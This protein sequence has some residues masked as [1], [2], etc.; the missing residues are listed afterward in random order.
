M[1]LYFLFTTLHVNIVICAFIIYRVANGVFEK[2]FGANWAVSVMA[3]GKEYFK[4]YLYKTPPT[5]TLSWAWIG[6]SGCSLF[7][8]FV[9][10]SFVHGF[11]YVQ[12]YQRRCF[13]LFSFAKQLNYSIF[14]IILPNADRLMFSFVFLV[15]RNPYFLG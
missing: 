5:K 15:E 14:C 7:Q 10:K 4:S 6:L 8:P 1:F 2:P 9:Y 11:K 13:F 12:G 3:K